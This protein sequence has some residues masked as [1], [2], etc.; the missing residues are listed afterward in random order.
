MENKVRRQKALSI[1]YKTL[2]AAYCL[3]AWTCMFR[4][5]GNGDCYHL[6]LCVL[7]PAIPVAVVLLFRAL[8]LRFTWHL[9]LVIMIFI[10]LAYLLGSCVDLY[11]SLP[12]YDK[13]IHSVSGLFV[14][15]LCCVAYYFIK[16]SH[17][18]EALDARILPVFVFCGSMT[19]AGLWEIWEYVMSGLTGQDLQFV[20]ETGVSDTMQDMICC[21]VGTIAF[22]P[23][24]VRL[25]NGKGDWLTGA[26]SD[27]IEQNY[28]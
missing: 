27:F 9:N 20:A 14:S 1:A 7:A 24:A 22:L 2:F 18:L 10:T 25:G 28:H 3:G 16:S 5:I 19:V 17:A 15:L 21:L 12:G 8:K 13:F 4:Y 11:H 23:S 6:W 26:V